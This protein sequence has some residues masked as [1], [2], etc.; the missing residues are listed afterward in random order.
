MKNVIVLEKRGG[1]PDIS[2]IL[3]H[4]L[5]ASANDFE[6]IADYLQRN[7]S[8]KIRFIL[9]NANEIPVTINNSIKMPAWYDITGNELIDR[10]DEIGIN[11][12]FSEIKKL[13]EKE[14]DNGVKYEKIFLGGFSQGG[15]MALHV[16]LKLNYPLSGIICL[17]GYL[18]LSR[19]FKNEISG[20]VS[21]TPIFMGHGKDDE[22]V[23]YEW[24]VNTRQILESFNYKVTWKD[25]EG[26]AHYINSQEIAHLSEF[27]NQ[28]I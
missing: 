22:V 25:Y 14:K 23:K 20:R 19:K 11:N 12:S 8:Q 6:E 5:G 16:G 9:P 2:V 17:S 1:K 3:L 28:N 4:G 18:L 21:E 24:G 13:I 15:A 27:I 10:Q 7:C 26:L